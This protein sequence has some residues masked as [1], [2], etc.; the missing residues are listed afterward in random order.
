MG[1]RATLAANRCWG[2]PITLRRK[3]FD[4]LRVL[5]ANAGQALSRQYLLSRVLGADETIGPCT[6]DF[7]IRCLRLKIEIDP[8]RPTLIQTV[9]SLGY[10]FGEAE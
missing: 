9:H 8:D 3:E 6:V 4:L 5:M 7:H 10:R 1:L 2:K